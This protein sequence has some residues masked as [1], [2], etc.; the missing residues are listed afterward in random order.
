MNAT[1]KLDLLPRTV[2]RYGRQLYI[3]KYCT[4]GLRHARVYYI[5]AIV[6][7]DIYQRTITNIIID[8]ISYYN[9]LFYVI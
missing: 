6:Y 8:K 9:I 2:K 1:Y 7:D 3:G 4:H 5:I